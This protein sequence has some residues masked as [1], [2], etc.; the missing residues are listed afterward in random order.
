MSEIRFSHVTA[1][2]V[3][4]IECPDCSMVLLPLPEN[5]EVLECNGCHNRFRLPRIELER[6]PSEDY[7]HAGL[8]SETTETPP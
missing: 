5:R 8:A 6:M 3:G 1:F 7:T 4:A 2:F